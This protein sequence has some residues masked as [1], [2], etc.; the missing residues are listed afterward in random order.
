MNSPSVLAHP[1]DTPHAPQAIADSL[2]RWDRLPP[3]R[4]RELTMVL[5]ALIVKQLPTSHP[6]HEEKT[7]E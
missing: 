4:Q 2:P 6:A 5:A 7:D 1:L 3:E